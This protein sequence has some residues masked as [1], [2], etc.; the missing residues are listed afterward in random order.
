MADFSFWYEGRGFALNVPPQT[1]LRF[2]S[3]LPV[4]LFQ[5]KNDALGN[6]PALRSDKEVRYALS[7][8]QKDRE[9]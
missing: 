5:G 6:T 9:A 2:S 1:S 7:Y 8:D 3:R 4:A